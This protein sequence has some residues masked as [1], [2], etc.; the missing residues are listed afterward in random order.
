MFKNH[1][2]YINFSILENNPSL[3][4]IF[5]VLLKLLNKFHSRHKFYNLLDQ[6]YLILI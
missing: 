4:S 6:S 5:S 1:G 3:I 2:I